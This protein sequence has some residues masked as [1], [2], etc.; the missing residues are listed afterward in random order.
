MYV[1]L[2]L[3]PAKKSKPE[4]PAI[5]YNEQNPENARNSPLSQPRIADPTHLAQLMSSSPLSSRRVLISAI[6]SLLARSDD[7]PSQFVGISTSWSWQ[8]YGKKEGFEFRI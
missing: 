7:P 4:P 8:P 1:F 6:H 2:L 3:S 5:Q